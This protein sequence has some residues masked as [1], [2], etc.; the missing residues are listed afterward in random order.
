MPK[1]SCLMVTVGRLELVR[2]AVQCFLN[3]TYENKELVIVEHGTFHLREYILAMNDERIRYESAQREDI[4]L[5][6]LRNR[7]IELARGELIAPWDDDDWYHPSRLAVQF[8]CLMRSGADVCML[9]RETF[10]W[11]DRELYV[12]SNHRL[13]KHSSLA[14][15]TAF[16]LYPALKGG[17]DTEQII[18]T[19]RDGA[20]LCM[21]N[22]PDLYIYT[23][24]GSNFS[25]MWMLEG[26]F[27]QATAPLTA[28][29]RRVAEGRLK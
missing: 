3:Q 1:I 4:T 21:I 10:V 25:D 23:V 27:G 5:G 8:A 16:A 28:K 29:Q 26:T 2:R 22:A 13:W 24:H 17:E 18:S 14:R 6:E 12:Y 9:S 11:P 20:R 7:S 19:I 15:K